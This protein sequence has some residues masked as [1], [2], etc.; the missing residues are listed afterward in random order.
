MSH[1]AWHFVIFFRVATFSSKVATFGLEV[2]SFASKL[3][4]FSS[5]R[6]KAGDKTW[7]KLGTKLGTS[8]S[9][10]LVTYPFMNAHKK[11][12]VTCI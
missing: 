9:E 2:A 1:R 6:D 12:Y 3:A 7:D 5:S 10:G 4:S 11:V 8:S